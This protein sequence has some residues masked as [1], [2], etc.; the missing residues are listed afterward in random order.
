MR[1]AEA[2]VP[3]YSIVI[4]VLNEEGSLRELHRQLSEVMKGRFEP[5]E[6]VFVDDHSLDSTPEILAELADEDHRVISLRLKRKYG[7]TV[8]LAAG[9][10]HAT[11]DIIISMDGDLQ[12]DP[13]DI[14]AMVE[15]LEAADADIV[16]GWRQKRVDNFFFRRTPSRVANWLIAKLSGVNIHDFGTTFKVYRRETIKDVRLYGELHRFIPA[17]ASLNGAKVI[18]VPI[19]NVPRPQGKSHYGISRTSRVFFDLITI[20]FLL[21]Y[22]LRPLHFFGPA[23]MISFLAGGGILGF[24]FL[25]K[26]FTGADIF[27][28]HGPLLILGMLLSL[29]GLQFLAT[30]L[31]GELMMR[32]Y[33]EAHQRPVYRLERI[34]NSPRMRITDERR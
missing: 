2:G 3:K 8:A 31:V 29:F 33:F 9:F 1:D 7:Q 22:M 12:H 25:D 34:M 18:E 11:G 17:L 6:F 4:P 27:V 20:R 13:A 14:P 10:D 23:G 24:L 19:R 15:A 28:Q 26:V 16:S 32:N 30:G 5:V 21:R